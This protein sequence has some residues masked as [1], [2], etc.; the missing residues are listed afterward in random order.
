MT[1]F[2]SMNGNVAAE[3]S[4]PEGAPMATPNGLKMEKADVM[5]SA[6]LAPIL[7]SLTDF[8]PSVR[9]DA[10]VS[11]LL[12]DPSAAW[13]GAGPVAGGVS[14]VRGKAWDVI[15]W[16]CNLRKFSESCRISC[17]FI[18]SFLPK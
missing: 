4:P 5:P 17:S 11:R 7:G 3:P 10:S 1:V 6:R 18:A 15:S 9:D 2:C 14:R 16:S 12:D 8:V 13:I